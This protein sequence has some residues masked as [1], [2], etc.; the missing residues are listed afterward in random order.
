MV[1]LFG[2]FL[3]S[4]LTTVCGATQSNSAKLGLAIGW[5]WMDYHHRKKGREEV[6][7]LDEKMK[8]GQ[9]QN[10]NTAKNWVIIKWTAA[11]WN[12]SSAQ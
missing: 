4:I 2:P 3:S 5:E 1:D 12:E 8:D 10:P 6:L 7:V 9:P 11:N